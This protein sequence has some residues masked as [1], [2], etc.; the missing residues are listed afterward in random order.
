MATLIPY[1][2]KKNVKEKGNGGG[3]ERERNKIDK[4][5]RG[6]F[7]RILAP[8]LPGQGCASATNGV[9]GLC[10]RP[11]AAGPVPGAALGCTRQ[12]TTAGDESVRIDDGV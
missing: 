12:L 1:K 9:Q 5:G 10:R 6:P 2:A 7:L 4:P 11:T 8:K 3:R